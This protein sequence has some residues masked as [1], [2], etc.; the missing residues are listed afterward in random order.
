[1]PVYT[2]PITPGNYYHFAE[3]KND[4]LTSNIS[5]RNDNLVNGQV[6]KQPIGGGLQAGDRVT[7]TLECIDSTMYQYYYTLEQTK[8]QNSATPA[9]PLSNIK[10]G[11]L[12]YF[13]AH[14]SH[15]RSVLVP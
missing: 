9:N 11:A 1:V 3:V 14:T 4:T 5:I 8:N 7:L 12:G 6:I 10:G 2:D 13:S 15:S